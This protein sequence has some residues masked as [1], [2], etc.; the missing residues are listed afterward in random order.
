MR[1]AHDWL[2]NAT[3]NVWERVHIVSQNME[4][5]IAGYKLCNTRV[6]IIIGE[7]LGIVWKSCDNEVVLAAVQLLQFRC[8]NTGQT[9]PA[10]VDI[11]GIFKTTP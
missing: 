5:T 8:A 6:G 2:T 7:L 4:A 1:R 3:N 9:Y 10:I 11:S